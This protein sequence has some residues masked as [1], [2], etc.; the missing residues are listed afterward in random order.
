M[1]KF[2]A[3]YFSQT[4]SAWVISAV[5]TNKFASSTKQQSHLASKAVVH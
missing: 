3:I 1:P 5:A 4:V 2:Q